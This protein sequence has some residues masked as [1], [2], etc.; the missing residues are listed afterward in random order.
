ML[1]PICRCNVVLAVLLTATLSARAGDWTRFRGP[2]GAGLSEDKNIPVKFG[3][4][5]H[6]V[7]KVTV[8]GLGNSSPIISQGKIFLQTASNDGTQRMILCLAAKNG[9]ILWTQTS[10]GSTATTHAKNTLASGSATVDGKR[11]YMPFWD[12]N[13]LAV[14]AYDYEGNFLWTHPLGVVKSQHGSGH[15]PIVVGNKVII[16]SDHDNKAEV[17]AMNS[18]TGAEAWKK[19]RQKFTASYSTPILLERPGSTPDV[20]VVSTPGATGYDPDTGEERW[21]WKWSGNVSTKKLR[22]V[23]S[24]VLVDK[25]LFFGG[26][27]GPGDR[28]S[29]GVPVGGAGDLGDKPAWEHKKI[30]PYV[31]CAVAKDDHIYF[32]NDEGIAACISAKTGKFAWQQRMEGGNVTSSPLLID[33]KVYCFSEEGVATVFAADPAGLKVLSTTTLD[34]GVMASPAVVDGRLYV[35]GKQHLYSFGN[36]GEQRAAK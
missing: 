21:S 22:S 23:G 36:A 20:I 34:E 13:A 28:Y 33:G 18:E 10:P 25:L 12:G 29:V 7:W 14:S 3:E 26:G 15:S 30:V 9:E 17:V 16:A 4:K 27:N 11:V 24:P 1:R 2:N 35:R 31:P 5:D 6:L 32:V 19:E 8:P